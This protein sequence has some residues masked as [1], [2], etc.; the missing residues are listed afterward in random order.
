MILITD[1]DHPSTDVERAVFEAAGRP[2]R[3]ATCRTE[4]EI[5]DEGR[6]AVALLAQYA[7]IT[8]QVLEALPNVRVVGRYGVGLDTIDLVAAAELGV[9]VL[10][11]PDYCVDEVANHTIGLILALTRG[12]VELDRGVQRGTW[13]F[14]LGGELRRPGAQRLGLVGVG[15]I[16][17]A[18]AR[19]AIALGYEVVGEDPA[20]P[21]ADGVTFVT[22]DELLATSD[23]VSLHASLDETTEHLINARALARMKPGAVLVNT[24]RGRLIDEAALVAALRAGRLGGAALDVLEREPIDPANLLIGMPNVVLTPHAAFYSREA[25]VEMKQ[26][27]AEKIVDALARHAT[28]APGRGPARNGGSRP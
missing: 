28:G 20:R 6:D 2:F 14:R 25:L 23:V 26:R 17:R 13:D 15:R 4:A 16:G 10:N 21:E 3:L 11:V 1:C 24:A 27:V 19:R 9:P 22:L 5:I 12:L 7:P 18:V 8:R